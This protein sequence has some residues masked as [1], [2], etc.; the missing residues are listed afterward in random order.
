VTGSGYRQVTGEVPP[1]QSPTANDYTNA[2][3]P[4]IDY[5]QDA[6]ALKGGAPLKGMD[7]I[8]ALGV[9]KGQSP[10]PE[11]DRIVPANVK[12]LGATDAVRDGMF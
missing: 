2:G 6:P 9:K 11:N 3:L 10:L 7:S 5:Y 1:T 4:W 8:D 12:T